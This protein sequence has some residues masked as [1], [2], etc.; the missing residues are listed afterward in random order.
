MKKRYTVLPATGRLN[1]PKAGRWNVVNARSRE[2]MRGPYYS[3]A[4]AQLI[5]DAM[6]DAAEDASKKK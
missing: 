2:V 4:L 5:A 1:R 3:E 6:N